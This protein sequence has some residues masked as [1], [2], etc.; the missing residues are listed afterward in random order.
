MQSLDNKQISDS[1]IHLINDCV[2]YK[3]VLVRSCGKKKVEKISTFQ[4][5]LS[6]DAERVRS[7]LRVRSGKYEPGLILGLNV[8]YCLETP[9][10]ENL[11]KF[12]KKSQNISRA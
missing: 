1:N 11:L 8:G 6:A 4:N 7:G 9:T 10:L 2:H 3:N 5:V 12:L